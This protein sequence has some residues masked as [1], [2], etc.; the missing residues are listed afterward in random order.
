MNKKGLGAIE[1]IVL[2][3][4]MIAGLGGAWLG[5]G[6]GTPQ[7]AKPETIIIDASG[8]EHPIELKPGHIYNA[9][10]RPDGTI[11]IKEQPK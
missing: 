5:Y 2:L 7:A 3:S 4:S 8:K 10:I 1:L 9:E 6:Y 11:V